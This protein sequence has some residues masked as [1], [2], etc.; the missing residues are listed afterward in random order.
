MQAFE[1]IVIDNAAAQAPK[2]LD[3]RPL[4]S[5]VTFTTITT[6]PQHV[7]TST[8]GLPTQPQPRL[9]RALLH[10]VEMCSCAAEY[11]IAATVSAALA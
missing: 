8:T 6:A 10:A 3:P 11:V 7:T 5:T 1:S 4:L 2:L 9:A